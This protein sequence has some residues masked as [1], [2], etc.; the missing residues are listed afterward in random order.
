MLC[1]RKVHFTV[2][3]TVYPF[4]CRCRWRNGVP[5]SRHGIPKERVS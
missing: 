4:R 5:A 1:Q 3:V 2:I